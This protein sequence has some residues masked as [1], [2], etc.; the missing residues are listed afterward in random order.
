MAH[1]PRMA[2]ADH[3]G[4]SAGGEVGELD[5]PALAEHGE[6]LDVYELMRGEVGGGTPTIRLLN[7]PTARCSVPR[8]RLAR[9]SAAERVPQGA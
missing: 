4:L 9:P 6:K 1:A 7:G 5:A 2:G 3:R 8:A